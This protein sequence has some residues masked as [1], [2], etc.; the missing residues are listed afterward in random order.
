MTGTVQSQLVG[1]VVTVLT[2]VIVGVSF[3]LYRIARWAFRPG[4]AATVIFDVV[5]WLFAATVVFACLLVYSWGEVRFY[6]LVGFAVGFGVYRMVLGRYVLGVAVSAY[7]HVQYARKKMV[8]GYK[9]GALG[10]KR[11]SKALWLRVKREFFFWRK[12]S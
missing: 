1:L 4:R 2:G 3:D 10:L 7:E 11:A 5:F 8:L 12:E 6:M 9:E